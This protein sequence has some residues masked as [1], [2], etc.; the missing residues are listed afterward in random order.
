MCVARANTGG[1]KPAKAQGTNV[2]FI[3]LGPWPYMS[4]SAPAWP[5]DGKSIGLTVLDTPLLPIG[6]TGLVTVERVWKVQGGG[7]INKSKVKDAV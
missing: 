5:A 6:R 1:L 2:L 3:H 4:C 7:F